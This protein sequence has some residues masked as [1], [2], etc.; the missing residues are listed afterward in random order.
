MRLSDYSAE[1]IREMGRDPRVREMALY[2]QHGKISTYRH[3]KSVAELSC[4]LS[5]ALHLPVDHRALVRGAFLHDYFL[6][7]WHGYRGRPLHGFAHPG[8]ALEN[9]RRD[10]DLTAKEE[11]I[12]AS[13]MWPLLPGKLPRSPEAVLVC[14]ADK[15]CSLRETVIRW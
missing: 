1:L 11:N 4:R 9:A 14:L 6:Y 15:I 5:E 2:T 3:C 8:I 12:I 10:F 7:D 13:H